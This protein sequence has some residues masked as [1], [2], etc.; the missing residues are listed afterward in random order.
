MMATK[1]KIKYLLQYNLI[2]MNKHILIFIFTALLV[3][4]KKDKTEE[5]RTLP[6]ESWGD[7]K[8]IQMTFQ[9]KTLDINA[10]GK[11]SYD[12]LG[13]VMNSLTEL[14][15]NYQCHLSWVSS[16][17]ILFSLPKANI[18]T[19]Q[20]SNIP[21]WNSFH[22]IAR[23]RYEYKIRNSDNTMIYDHSFITHVDGNWT[24]IRYK[25]GRLYATLES[26]FYDFSMK[27]FV[28]ANVDAVFQKI[29]GDRSKYSIIDLAAKIPLIYSEDYPEK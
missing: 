11:E 13:Q 9:T 14:S 2:S 26:Q 27:R 16:Q 18:Y 4:C 3:G 17:D 23:W 29:E 21:S 1:M 24:N 8:V 5:Y 10:D 25:D 28:I 15:L 20:T 12:Y 6:Q 22:K 7:Y 19:I